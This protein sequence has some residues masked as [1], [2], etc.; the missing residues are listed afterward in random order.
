MAGRVG[1]YVNYI[2]E[3]NA[4][5]DWLEFNPIS[6][7]TQALWS[8][9]MHYNN[10]C[11]WLNEFSI[12][13]SR[14]TLALGISRTELDRIRNVLVQKGLL[15]YKKG[16]GNKAGF[17][18]LH[19][20][21][22]HNVTQISTQVNTQLLTQVGAQSSVQSGRSCCTLYKL[23]KTKLNNN[24][25][26]EKNSDEQKKLKK[27]EKVFVE[28]SDE[29]TLALFL[30]RC[31]LKNDSGIKVPDEHKLQAWAKQFDYMLRLDKRDKIEISKVIKWATSDSFWRQN[32]LSASKLRDKYD[33]LKLKMNSGNERKDKISENLEDCSN[34]SYTDT[35][36]Y[37][38]YLKNLE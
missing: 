2:Q 10:K 30:R 26:S 8:L 14:I 27:S 13:N 37:L 29:M 12:A 35:K 23:N 19:S 5:Y 6:G 38:E 7:N 34:D 24:S 32:I 9:L 4:F 17:Y 11:G 22:S 1:E 36:E 3:I 15:T 28:D 25:M 20:L 18:V 21:V 31:I 16:I 33:Q